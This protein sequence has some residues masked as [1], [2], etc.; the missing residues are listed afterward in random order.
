MRSEPKLSEEEKKSAERQPEF[1]LKNKSIVE[2][3]FAEFLSACCV[4]TKDLNRREL[5]FFRKF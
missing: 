5:R 2:S 1:H 3:L 4:R